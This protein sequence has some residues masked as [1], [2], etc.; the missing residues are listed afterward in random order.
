MTRYAFDLDGTL[1]RTQGEDY[2]AAQPVAE[3]VAEVNRLFHEGHHICI[4]TAR[5]AR[6]RALTAEQLRRWGVRYHVL[7]V[8]E[9]WPADTYVDDRAIPVSDWAVPAAGRP[10]F[11]VAE[12]GINH[13]GSVETA[14]QLVAAA[15]G[16]GCDAVKF[17]VGDPEAYVTRD[18]WDQPRETPWGTLRYID[19]RKR[20]EFDDAALAELCDYAAGLGVE[21]F[22]SPL[23]V[24]AVARLGSLG[25]RRFKIAS[26]MLTDAALLAAVRATG[27][28]AI[29]STG[30]STLAQV[31]A[32]VARLEPA[33]VMHC[34][35]A[36]PCPPELVNL[37]VIPA[38][39]ARYGLPV[40]YSGHE[41]GLAT[42]V[43]AVALGAELVERHITLSRAMWGS[44]QAASVEPEGFRRLV[45]DI[46][47]VE[48]ALGDGTKRV[49][50]EESVNA[51]K[52]RR[53]A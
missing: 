49:Y 42:T 36:Y 25:V 51:A 52:F 28:P 50:A 2:A 6:H 29:L 27:K 10:V 38:L 43:A 3:R 39:R 5:A 24:G 23:D 7:R 34:T 48:R 31:D 8:G 15:A 16:A 22:A 20:L 9:K 30:M 4:D 19:Y 46:R 17:Q 21:W 18:R 41:V 35:S 13:N 32:A 33:A 12:V 14:K 40:G 53:A 47:T 37:R 26:P 45:R 44:D 11:V 1:C